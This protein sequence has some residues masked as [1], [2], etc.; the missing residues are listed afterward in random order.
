MREQEAT[1]DQR[2]RWRQTMEMMG[3]QWKPE[4]EEKGFF[5]TDVQIFTIQRWF[6]ANG[7]IIHPLNGCRCMCTFSVFSENTLKACI[8]EPH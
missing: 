8:P 6:K 7:E 3:E 4:T 2:V 1:E 5:L